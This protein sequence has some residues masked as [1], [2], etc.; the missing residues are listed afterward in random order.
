MPPYWFDVV[1]WIT[2]DE[3]MLEWVTITETIRAAGDHYVTADL[4]AGYGRWIV[5]AALVARRLGR[6]FFVIRVEAEDTHFAWMCCRHP[7]C[8]T[9]RPNRV[10]V[11]SIDVLRAN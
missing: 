3:Q 5:N 4:G 10:V 6:T 2:V 1:N 7:E 11:H 8:I 9:R